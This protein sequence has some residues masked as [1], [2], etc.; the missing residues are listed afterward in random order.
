MYFSNALQGGGNRRYRNKRHHVCSTKMVS[1][2]F[3]FFVA[4]ELYHRKAY[5][6]NVL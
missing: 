6:L 1:L 4:A 2:H 3:L 5:A